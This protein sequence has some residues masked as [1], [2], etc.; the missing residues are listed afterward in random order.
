MTKKN[1]RYIINNVEGRLG[2]SAL[3]V[4][5]VLAT[6]AYTTATYYVVSKTAA[7]V[8]FPSVIWL[9]VANVLV[10]SIF[11]LNNTGNRYSLFPSKEEGPPTE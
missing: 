10:W 8:L 9:S 3:V 7:R 4:P 11:K 6:A 2:T 1:T 5:L